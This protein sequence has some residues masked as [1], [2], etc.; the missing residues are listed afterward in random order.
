MSKTMNVESADSAE[1][2]GVGRGLP[3]KRILTVIGYIGAV[4]ALSYVAWLRLPEVT[5]GTI[6]AEDGTV[7]LRET[8]VIGPLASI[9]EPYAGYLHTIPRLIS[10]IS[11]LAGPLESC[12]VLMSFFSCAVV[13]SISVAVF[14]LSAALVDSREIRLM[15]ALI[16]VFVPVGPLEVLGN[17]ANLHWYMLWLV[18]WLLIYEPSRWKGKAVLLIVTFAAAT[19]E[20]ISGIFLPLALWQCFR[21]RQYAAPI[22][23]VAGLVCQLMATASKPRY[24]SLPQVDALEPLS[25]F[26]G[27]GLQ[28]MTSLWETDERSVA[29]SIVNF[30]AYAALIPVAVISCLLIYVLVFGSLKWKFVG[31]YSFGAAAVC[32]TAAVVLNVS[33]EFDF[34]NFTE[35]D[36]L[37][38]FKFFR[39]AAAPSMFLLIMVPASW[40]VAKERAGAMRNKESLRSLRAPALMLIF[41]SVNYFPAL[42]ARA[43]GPEWAEGLTLARDQCAAN[44]GLHEAAIPLAP[45]LW[46]T[47]L[48]CNVILDS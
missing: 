17:A 35:E 30:G 33:P 1:T 44:P 24:A 23:L 11:Y 20:I 39:Y 2:A 9:G 16:P 31:V 6:W 36:W 42:P 12:A 13:A 5:R 41:L 4:V 15:L 22:G 46:Y 32:W 10:A 28:A 45:A 34:A 29:S 21:R 43:T 25:V 26:Y 8:V 37:S 3:G 18:P 27:F 38:K 14:H 19:T 48:P 40:A 7:F 47:V